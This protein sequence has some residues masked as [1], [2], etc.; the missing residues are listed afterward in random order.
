MWEGGGRG[1]AEGGG[2]GV[3]GDQESEGDL[4]TSSSLGESLSQ[5]QDLR[6]L[7]LLCVRAARSPGR[8]CPLLCGDGSGHDR[9]HFVSSAPSQAFCICGFPGCSYSDVS[10]GIFPRLCSSFFISEMGRRM[11]LPLLCVKTPVLLLTPACLLEGSGS[12][13]AGRSWQRLSPTG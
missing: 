8:P 10:L 4:S 12:C 1:C 2:P 3:L 9:G 11:D 6:R 5:D 7:L 13:R